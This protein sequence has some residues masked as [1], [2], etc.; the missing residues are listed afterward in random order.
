MTLQKAGFRA[1][2][3]Y[4]CE[5]ELVREVAK[6]GRIPSAVHFETDFSSSSS[7]SFLLL[8]A[9]FFHFETE[10]FAIAFQ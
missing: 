5:S 10:R 3:T 8:P 1:R 4:L 9:F 7:L 6:Y 2:H